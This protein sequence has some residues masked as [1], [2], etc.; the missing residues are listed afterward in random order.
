MVADATAKAVQSLLTNDRELAI[1]VYRADREINARRFSIEHE[2]LITIATQQPLATDLRVLASIIEVVTELERM[3]DYAKGIAKINLLVEPGK[4]RL[5][6]I[7]SL[8]EMSEITIRLL[9]RALQAF[10][11]RDVDTARSLPVEDDAVDALFNRIYRN[12]VAVM[13]EDR[14]L[15]ELSNHLQWAAHNIE[16]MSDR[17]INICERI[18]FIQTGE[19]SELEES[20]DETV[21]KI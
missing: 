10:V 7:D 9:T 4:V 5:D 11:A 17:V 2:C 3:G 15:I 21:V 19:M 12:L 20:D 13:I 16:R 8:S 6:A 18:I 1:Q 14:D